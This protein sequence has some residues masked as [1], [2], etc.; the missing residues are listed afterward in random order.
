[1]IHPIKGVFAGLATTT[2]A[3]VTTS[4]LAGLSVIDFR[5]AA[6]PVT[7]SGWI[8]QDV[9]LTNNAQ[10]DR[11]GGPCEIPIGFSID[12]GLGPVDTLYLSENGIVSFGAALPDGDD[13][14]LT[15][16][17]LTTPVI[18]PFYTDLISNAEVE[19]EVGE[20]WW[21]PGRIDPA[22][23]PDPSNDTS[24]VTWHDGQKGFRVDWFGVTRP[25]GTEGV[26]C[27]IQMIIID[28]PGDDFDLI[29]NYGQVSPFSMP[30]NGAKIGFRLGPNSYRF[31]EP[32]IDETTDLKFEF[33]NGVWTNR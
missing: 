17:Q 10:C 32:T 16:G 23:D 2:L 3:F 24:P 20:I 19:D 27:Y 31:V 26:R 9:D 6:M 29:F 11:A 22:E 5:P 13:G 28:Q 25:G 14:S 12:F 33:R 4:A 30:V 7:G 18:A 8:Y 21:A 15:A 1:M